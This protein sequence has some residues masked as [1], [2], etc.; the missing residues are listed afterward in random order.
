[1]INLLAPEMKRQ[2]RAARTNVVLY[3]YCMLIL[4][5]AILLGGVF[6]VGFLADMNDRKFAE[7]LKLESEASAQPY[8]KTKAAA[9]SFAK[10]LTAARTILS[11]NSS[12]SKL[13]LDIAAAVPGGVILNNL[14]LST[15]GKADAP[16]DISG[17]AQSYDAAVALKNSLDASPVFEKVNIV[18]VSQ[19]EITPQTTD[20]IKKYPFAVS[21]KAQKTPATQG[22]K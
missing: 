8:A 2:I 6:T 16:I 20:I 15:T 10:D 13:I 7:N 3:R 9:E 14:T 4:F 18:N 11:S 1:M 22:A 21:I 17:R 5:T 12:F 19:A